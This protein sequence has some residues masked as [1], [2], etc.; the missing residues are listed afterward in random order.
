MT[1]HPNRKK[2]VYVTLSSLGISKIE[3]GIEGNGACFCKVHGEN[4]ES[5]YVN[6]LDIFFDFENIEYPAWV[7]R[8]IDKHQVTRLHLGGWRRIESG[9]IVFGD[10]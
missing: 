7:T 1:N 8:S 9:K 4:G 5:F 6:D 10:F 3:K 2:I